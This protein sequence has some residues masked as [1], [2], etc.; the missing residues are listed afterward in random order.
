[1]RRFSQNGQNPLLS[2]FNVCQDNITSIAKKKNN[3][4]VPKTSSRPAS[5]NKNKDRIWDKH[6]G[7]DQF[8]APF[9][10]VTGNGFNP[11]TPVAHQ[12]RGGLHHGNGGAYL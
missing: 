12:V 5:S 10:A 7:I 11:S 2:S 6:L 3:Y 8:A 4:M 9:A 1:M